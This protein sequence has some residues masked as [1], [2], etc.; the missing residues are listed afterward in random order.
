MSSGQ[1]GWGTDTPYVGLETEVLFLKD[2]CYFIESHFSLS[3]FENI[4]TAFVFL[5]FTK[6]KKRPIKPYMEKMIKITINV[7][8]TRFSSKEYYM[9]IY[10]HMYI[11]NF[12]K[13]VTIYI[14]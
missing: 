3:T 11:Y 2:R 9:Y 4:N 14:Y 5:P 6:N 12:T 8:Y 10:I 7:Q 1:W 13:K